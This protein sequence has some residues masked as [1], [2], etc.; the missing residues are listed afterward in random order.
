MSKPH[1]ILDTEHH[2]VLFAD[3]E[4]DKRFWVILKDQSLD[5]TTDIKDPQLK[6]V[7]DQLIRDGYQ[8]AWYSCECGC[9]VL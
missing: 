9:T 4:D 1:K 3:T 8:V 2:R 5:P 6:V 7:T